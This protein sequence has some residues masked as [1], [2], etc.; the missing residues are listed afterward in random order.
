MHKI[1]ISWYVLKITFSLK[2]YTNVHNILMRVAK[3][4]SQAVIERRINEFEFNKCLETSTISQW[5]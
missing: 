4:P 1:K 3:K 5:H 2:N